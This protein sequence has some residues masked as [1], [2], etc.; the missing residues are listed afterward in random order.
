MFRG[1]RRSITALFPSVSRGTKL[2]L[3]TSADPSDS[4]AE[5]RA[6]RDPLRRALRATQLFTR[7]QQ[8]GVEL[9]RI[10]RAA[11]EEAV[12]GGMSWAEVA[13]QTGVSRGRVS[14]IKKDAPVAEREFFGVGP[15]RLAVPL[16][17]LPGRALPVI[18]QEDIRARDQLT[19]ALQA[20]SFTVE[21]GEI[22]AGQDWRP[23]EADLIAICGPKSSPTIERLLANDP[24]IEF[25]ADAAGRWRITERATGTVH[26]S[27]MDED[28]DAL[29]D[30]AYLGRLPFDEHRSL[31]LIAGVHAMGSLGAVDYLVT[32]LPELHRQTGTGHFSMAIACQFTPDATITSSDVAC[33][34][35]LH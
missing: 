16:R 1:A 35:L 18:A 24:A 22:S 9:A 26:G 23:V 3:V 4:L 31:L 11:I 28:P 20:L 25:A 7:W 15:I 19:E 14:Q 33:G 34:P 21:P 5:L 17:Q 32:H 29:A 13:R 8:E 2:F 27:P 12:A 6:E 30:V 10:R